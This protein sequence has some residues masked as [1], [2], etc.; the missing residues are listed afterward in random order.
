MS[1]VDVTHDG[2]LGIDTLFVGLVGGEDVGEE[3]FGRTARVPP[4]ALVLELAVGVAAETLM[5]HMGRPSLGT[6]GGRQMRPR[7]L[8]E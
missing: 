8:T 3:D 2:G 4:A 1:I 6:R 7:G 5:R